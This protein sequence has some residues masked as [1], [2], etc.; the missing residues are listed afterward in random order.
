MENNNN[1][2][3][4]VEKIKAASN[5]LRGT[6]LESLAD[7]I[8]GA[9]S[10]DDTS[11]LKFHGSY[12]QT[13]RDLSSERKKQKLEPLYNFMI[14]ARL[15]AG[16]ISSKQWLTIN[17]LADKYGNGTMKLT[18]RQTFQLHGILK[19][20]LK[21][22]ILEIN[23]I[24][25]T[26]LATCGDVN[27]NV[28]S[29]PNPYLSKIH[30]EAF[31][32]AVRI[33]N[34]LLPKTSAYYEIWLDKEKVAGNGSDEEPIY[35]PTYLPRK[36][37]I[38]IAV[39][40]YNDTDVFSN[41]IGLIAIEEN[42][43]L[44][45]YNVLAGGGMGM[46]FEDPATH[47]RLGDVLGFVSKDKMLKVVEEILKIQ[48]DKGNRSD[49]KFARLKYTIETMGLETFKKELTDRLG[50]ELEPSR[51]FNFI[52]NNDRFG[53]TQGD[54]NLWHYCLFVETGRIKDAD[55]YPLKSTL[56]QI[57]EKYNPTFI[58]TG[59]Q[60]IIIANV[61][62]KAKEHIDALLKSI[63]NRKP[64]TGMRQHSLACTALNQCPLAFAEAE[65]YLPSL[66]DKI[67]KILFELKLENE[68]INIR[69]TGCPNGCARPYLGEI[70]LVGR[71]IGKYNLYLG[72]N[73]QGSRL[74]VLYREMADEDTILSI[75]RDILQQF[76]AKR[77]E[78]ERL[79]DFIVRA[80]I[81]Q[82]P[83]VEI[84]I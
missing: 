52:S 44:L 15:T 78:N 48:R 61:E 47:P 49:R 64:L 51:P 42:N 1:N 71:T 69:M 56:K 5:Y 81:V 70:G 21:K 26:T 27:R 31:L 66:I 58:I 18:T 63:L 40:P 19:R 22:T 32:D 38:A 7:E 30:F 72:A 16:I 8:T 55:N 9:I 34:H 41:D 67:D 82:I 28:M 33:S 45:G 12:Q 24:M 29:S 53:W 4:E 43:R 46:S 39:P 65:R 20:N 79:G 62:E 25:I 2:V 23:Q 37:K 6:L 54:D 11:V 50:F 76:A 59:N 60:N 77:L 10:P 68:P 35:G 80:K 84:G 13:D 3:N 57:A 75:L 17:E 14:R 74:N 73:A 36:F 83:N